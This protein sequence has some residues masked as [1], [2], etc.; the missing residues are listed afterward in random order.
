MRITG[1]KARSIA[2]QSPKGSATRPATDQMRERIFSSLGDSVEGARCLDLFAGT[3][4]YGLEALSR[5]AAEVT[6]VEKHRG[7]VEIIRK[8]IQAVQRAMDGQIGTQILN[9]DVLGITLSP[10]TFD[11]IFIDPPYPILQEVAPELMEKTSLWSA[12]GL[13]IWELPLATTLSHPKWTPV[14]RLGKGRGNSPSAL[15]LQTVSGP[16]LA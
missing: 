12:H 6:F 4:A 14:K 15:I 16:Y 10:G 13:A 11:L 1:G 7:T 8:N 9:K 5:G 2:I 3:G